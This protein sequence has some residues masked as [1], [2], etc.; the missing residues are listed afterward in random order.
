MFD[1]WVEAWR[2]K[3]AKGDVIVVRFADDMVLGFEN[4]A[5]VERFLEAFRQRLAKFGLEL[6]ADKTRLIEFGLFA[7][8][9]LKRRGQ[10][11]P[12]TFT[13]LGFTH[14]CGE[15]RKT[16]TFIVPRKTAKKRMAAKLRLIKE[17]LRY[18]MHEPVASVGE[19]LQKV[20]AGY[21][22]YHAIPGVLD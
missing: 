10:G 18:R 6:H 8:R 5:D 11:K 15:R 20:V 12:E 19:W 17:E 16:R 9:N 7:A 1:L 3:L 21:Y 14:Y 2:K 13:V 22:R 4:R